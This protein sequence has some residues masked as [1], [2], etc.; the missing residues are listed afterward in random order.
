MSGKLLGIGWESP[1]TQHARYRLVRLSDP[2]VFTPPLGTARVPFIVFPVM[3][4]SA[5]K[6]LP[7]TVK[8]SRLPVSVPMRFPV[9]VRVGG[10][11]PPVLFRT[12]AKFS[13]MVP[14]TTLPDTLR[15]SVI[16]PRYSRNWSVS[17]AE[18]LQVPA[19]GTG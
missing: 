6:V 1:V 3:V 9:P 16:V 8:T 13:E 12:N 4:A 17:L 2:V 19:S 15:T 18:P 5:L 11:E 14:V 7:G 10:A